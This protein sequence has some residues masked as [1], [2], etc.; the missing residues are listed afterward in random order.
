MDRAR[1]IRPVEADLQGATALSAGELPIPRGLLAALGVDD[2]PHPITGGPDLSA[3]WR[4][5]EASELVVLPKDPVTWADARMPEAV[6][7]L[8]H[9]CGEPMAGGLNSCLFCGNTAR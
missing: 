7:T 1:G 4:S 3:F 6:V 9:W 2:G 8:C 5:A